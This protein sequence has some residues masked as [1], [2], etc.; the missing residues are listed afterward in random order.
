[1]KGMN[2]T[3]ET[4]DEEVLGAKSGYAVRYAKTAA[5]FR[6]ELIERYGAEKG[7]KIRYAEAFEVCEYGNPLTEELK[8]KLF[9]F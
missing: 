3:S 6:K 5:R 8:N 4:T 7:S 9:P 1:L 2:I